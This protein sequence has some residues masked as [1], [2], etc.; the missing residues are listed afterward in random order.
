MYRPDWD[1]DIYMN[2]YNGSAQHKELMEKLRELLSK[3]WELDFENQGGGELHAY[4]GGRSLQYGLIVG[5]DDLFPKKHSF[6]IEASEIVGGDD[7]Y[8]EDDDGDG[9]GTTSAWSAGT[10]QRTSS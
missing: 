7:E 10:T 4:A 3:V 5:W 2:D 1:I 8:D 9:K 6:T